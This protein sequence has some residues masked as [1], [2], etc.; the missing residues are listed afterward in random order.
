MTFIVFALLLSNT[1]VDLAI[2]WVNSVLHEIIPVVI[3]M[4]WLIDPPTVRLTRR[5]GL[6]WLSFPAAWIVYVL[7]RGAIVGKYPY[8]FLDPANGGYATVAVY[9]VGILI[10]MVAMCVAVVAIGG[11]ARSRHDLAAC[12]LACGRSRSSPRSRP[13]PMA[14]PSP[15]RRAGPRRWAT[16]R[17]S[18]RTTSSSSSR[19]S[20]PSR[21]S[22]PPRSGCAS[23]PSSTTTTCATRRCS[24][25]TSPAST[26]SVAVAWTWPSGPAGTGPSTT[27]SGSRSTRRPVRQARLEEAIAVLKGCFAD[28]PFSFAGEHYT[29]TDLDL[30][31]KPVQRPHPPFL[32][33]GGGRRTLALAGREA[34]IVGLAPRILSGQRSDPSSLTVAA[35][36]EKIGWVREAAGDRFD[37]LVFNVYPSTWPVTVTDDPRAEAERVIEHLR[38]RNAVDLTVDEVLE[39]PHLF[40]GTVDSL[41]DKLVMLR[42]RLGITSFMTGDIDE[43]APVVARLAGT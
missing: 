35:A 36:E 40:I 14:R 17:W 28:G 10:L 25:R 7:I 8:P 27:P 43:L 32:I 37:D 12:V 13:S 42:E 34:D 15:R 16:T 9:C 4:D 1:D 33:G 19:R 11:W 38:G 41:V 39:S 29:I 24:P 22:P 30:Y 20:R 21:R 5:Q 31:P 2:P 26:C 6:L 18:C 23:R 3:L